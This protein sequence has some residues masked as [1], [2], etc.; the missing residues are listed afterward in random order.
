LRRV[1][2]RVVI[3]LTVATLAAVLFRVPASGQDVTE[4]ALKA[5]FILNFAKFTQWPADAGSATSPLALCVLGDD[6]VGAEL[7]RSV[8]GRVI[9]GRSLTVFFAS[10]LAPR[11]CHLLYLSGMPASQASQVIA[12]L[13]D[14]PVLTVSDL[15]GFTD[16]GGIAQFYFEQGRLRFTIHVPSAKRVRLELSSRLLALAKLK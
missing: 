1:F 8:K 16:V 4:P 7:E 9:D 2:G 6:A 11:A 12:T 10:T 5:A 14:M 13:R 3:Q 15:D